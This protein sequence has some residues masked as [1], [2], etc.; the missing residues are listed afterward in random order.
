[1]EGEGTAEVRMGGGSKA[2]VVGQL[3]NSSWTVALCH[4][5]NEDHEKGLPGC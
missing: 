2:L 1:M 5:D 3:F 4:V